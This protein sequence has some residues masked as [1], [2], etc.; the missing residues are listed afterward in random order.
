MSPKTEEK[1]KK[2]TFDMWIQIMYLDWQSKVV[3]GRA[4]LDDFAEYVGYSRSLISM[5]MSGKRLPTDDGIKRLA[6]LFG[7]DIYVILGKPTPNPFLQKISKIWENIP[8]EKQQLLVEE[9]ERYELENDRSKKTS[10]QR[11]T[12]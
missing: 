6:E 8:P 9:A 1:N 5:W 7:D 4:S 2:T 12:A 11:K 3:K 10:K